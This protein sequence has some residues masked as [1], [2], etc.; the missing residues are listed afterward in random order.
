MFRENII[1]KHKKYPPADTLNFGFLVDNASQPIILIKKQK[2]LSPQSSPTLCSVPHLANQGHPLVGEA[3]ANG[4]A[5]DDTAPGVGPELA[6]LVPVEGVAQIGVVFFH[7][8]DHL[9]VAEADLPELVVGEVVGLVLALR[10]LWR[11]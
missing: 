10:F 7:E 9:D 6:V 3:A 11:R 1:K 5:N 2:R 4:V 8:T